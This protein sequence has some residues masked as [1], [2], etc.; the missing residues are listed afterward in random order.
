MRKWHSVCPELIL[1]RK[2][3]IS[4]IN[5]PYRDEQQSPYSVHIAGHTSHEVS[6][7]R[8]PQAER[9][10]G[11]SLPHLASGVLPSMAVEHTDGLLF[12]LDDCISQDQ[13]MA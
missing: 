7:M 6:E 1:E 3:R 12:S 10:S 13:N 9:P 5:F 11:A 2:K 4:L 8:P